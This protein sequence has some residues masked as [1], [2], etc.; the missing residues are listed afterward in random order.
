MIKNKNIFKNLTILGLGLCG[1]A[2]LSLGVMIPNSVANAMTSNQTSI[3][4]DTSLTVTG[5]GDSIAQ[6]G[7]ISSSDMSS[8]GVALTVTGDGGGMT[9][10][11]STTSS[12]MSS[13][14]STKNSEQSSSYMSSSVTNSSMTSSV[15]SSNTSKIDSVIAVIQ[16]AVGSDIT[17][18]NKSPKKFFNKDDS[19]IIL[20]EPH[21][22]TVQMVTTKYL[23]LNPDQMAIL[24]KK[25]PDMNQMLQDA[26]GSSNLTIG[27]SCNISYPPFRIRCTINISW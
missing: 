5:S 9:Q 20:R 21:S 27:V 14:S 10:N 11:S 17:V 1:I 3:T 26:S 4:S 2:V 7:D 23:V 19:L 22:K 8:S 16:K 13:L 12:D 25:L 6:S 15:A 24:N 18:L